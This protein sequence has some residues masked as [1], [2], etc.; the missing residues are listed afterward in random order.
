MMDGGREGGREWGGCRLFCCGGSPDWCWSSH[1]SQ[2]RRRNKGSPL[3]FFSLSLSA[4][5]KSRMTNGREVE[6][7]RPTTLMG[8]T[9]PRAEKTGARREKRAHTQTHTP[10]S[11]EPLPFSSAGPRRSI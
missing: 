8:F 10:R 9:E 3:L 1:V 6:T 11:S 5:Y 4:V 7:Q 2:R